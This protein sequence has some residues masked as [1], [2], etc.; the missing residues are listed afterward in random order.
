M[1]GR[2]RQARGERHSQVK[3]T[4]AAVH[5]IRCMVEQGIRHRVIAMEFGIS[6]PTVSNIK[7]G[8]SWGWLPRSGGTS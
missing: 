7:S 6:Q 4:E 8:K 2:S 5:K 1:K 3:L